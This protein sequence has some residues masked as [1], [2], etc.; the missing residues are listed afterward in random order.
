MY[1]PPFSPEEVREIFNSTDFQKY[2]NLKKELAKIIIRYLAANREEKKKNKIVYEKAVLFQ[3]KRMLTPIGTDTQGA[4]ELVEMT[5]ISDVKIKKENY[6]HNGA[7][8]LIIDLFSS[9][10]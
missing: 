5:A 2:N 8:Q 1:R 3:A 9:L 6:T 4:I 10:E 7:M